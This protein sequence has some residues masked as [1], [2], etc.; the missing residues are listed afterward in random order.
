MPVLEGLLCPRDEA[1]VMDMLFE[2]ANFHALGKLRLHTEVTIDILEASTPL[3]YGAIKRFATETCPKY[4]TVEQQKEVDS[5]VRR[6]RAKD[7]KIKV[8][9]QR[10]PKKFNVMNTYKYHAIGHWAG[11]VRRSGPLDVYS[12]QV[13]STLFSSHSL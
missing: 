11:Y 12:T 2:C 3:I 6:A 13:V 8:S 9:N 4:N 1:C 7:P 10:Q 5:R